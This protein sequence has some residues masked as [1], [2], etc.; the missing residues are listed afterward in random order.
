[1]ALRMTA[2]SGGRGKEV[3]AKRIVMSMGN[4]IIE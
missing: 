4:I 1:M 2:G 3:L